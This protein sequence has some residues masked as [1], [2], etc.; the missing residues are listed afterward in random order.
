M[1]NW[2][3][4]A[5]SALLPLILAAC[6]SSSSDDDDDAEPPPPVAEAPRHIASLDL[7]G[8]YESG[9][10]GVSAAEIPAYDAA[11]R[12][13]FVV[14]AQSGKIDVLDLSTPASPTHMG[15]L[16]AEAVSPGAEINSV[17]V[18]DGKVAVAIQ[19]A[20]KT[21][22]GYMALYDAASLALLGSVPV[23]AQ[24]DMLTF[25]PDAK[26]VLV[27]NE[28][29]PSDDYTIDPE[30]SVSVIDISNPAAPTARTAG[31]TAWNGQEAMLRSQGVR[32][33]GPRASAAQD[34]EPEYIA[35]DADGATAWVTLQENNALARLDVANARVTDIL[36]LGAKDHGVE[37]NGLDVSDTD[38][39]IDIRTWPGVKGLY[40]P[41]AIAAYKAGGATYLVTA[42]EGDGRP[43][44][45]DNPA[46]WNWGRDPAGTWLDQDADL[47]PGFV[48]EFRVKHLVHKDGFDRRAGDDLPPQLRKLAVGGLLDPAVFGYCGATATDPGDCRDDDLLGR[49]TVTWTMGYKQNPDGSPQLSAD[50]RLVYDTLYAYGARS[51]SIR[52]ADG[53][54]VWDS[55]DQFERITAERY[56]DWFNSGH[57]ET[58]FDDRSDNKGPEPEGIVLGNIGD[59]TYA[60][61]GLERIGGI[62]VYDISDPAQ[63]RFATYVNSRDFNV[64]SAADPGA[65][66]DL[67]PEGLAFVSAADSPTGEPLLIVGYEVSG[68][69]AIYRIVLADDAS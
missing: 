44:G 8:R 41:D 3:L 54:L 19:A 64:D 52:D 35:V 36:P 12:R 38:G 50:G 33:V 6:G 14:N 10:Y 20:V 16:D 17:A 63:P 23:G 48:D 1:K 7:L 22:T 39:A 49:L 27:A 24:P 11:T 61:V 9:S 26:T 47:A 42:N 65:A 68:T 15:T 53:K 28:G 66:G 13:A 43:W 45:E 25:T 18:R 59:K 2:K 67:G 21:D 32:L 29:E 4:A 58:L 62:M 40:M 31:F 5:A 37:G 51:F 57:D 30:G 56:P 69:T 46:Y 55:G 34:I 60:F